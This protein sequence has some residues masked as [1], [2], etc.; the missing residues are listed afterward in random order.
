MKP[1][2]YIQNDNNMIWKFY[3]TFNKKTDKYKCTIDQELA[4]A[5]A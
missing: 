4:D 5:A 1:C 2:L 3:C